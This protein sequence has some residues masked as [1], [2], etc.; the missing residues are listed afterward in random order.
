MESLPRSA[1]W[2]LG[3]NSP[4]LSDEEADGGGFRD[5]RGLLGDFYG[6]AIMR[7]GPV[8]PVG[9]L[10]V[11]E[12]DRGGAT[13]CQQT[14]DAS[15]VNCTRIPPLRQESLPTNP[16]GLQGRYGDGTSAPVTVLSP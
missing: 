11:H 1:G 7:L 12:P 14:T 10:A 3:P 9:S 13:D 4:H 15:T 2:T 5:L 16:W 8:P 6:Q